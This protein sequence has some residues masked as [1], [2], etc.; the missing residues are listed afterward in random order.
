MAGSG[1]FWTSI[2]SAALPSIISFGSGLFQ[3]KANEDALKEKQAY[4]EKQNALAF[5]QKK[6]L[7]ALQGGGG[8]GGGGGPFTGFTD[9]QRVQAMQGQN[10]QNMDAINAIIAAYQRALLK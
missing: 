7:L 9:P 3:N 4:D 2:A 8:G 6:E 10:Q 5:A 1:D